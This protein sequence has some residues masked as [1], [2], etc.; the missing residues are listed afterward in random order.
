MC[1][2][3]CLPVPSVP[4]GGRGSGAAPRRTS[5]PLSPPPAP[6]PPPAPGAPPPQRRS[7]RSV[8]CRCSCWKRD[9]A[10]RLH[11]HSRTHSLTTHG[12]TRLREEQTV[13]LT[14]HTLKAQ[15]CQLP[16]AHRGVCSRPARDLEASDDSPEIEVSQLPSPGSRPPLLVPPWNVWT[17]GRRRLVPIAPSWNLHFF[18][19]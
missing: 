16:E 5:P 11:A 9:D 2:V 8:T 7:C 19:S 4:V 12:T 15:D 6:P 17:N 3:G 14:R 13:D 18:S 10:T 1:C